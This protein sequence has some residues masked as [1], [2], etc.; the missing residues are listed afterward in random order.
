MTQAVWKSI[1]EQEAKIESDLI[2]ALDNIERT[3]H[4]STKGDNSP[5]AYVMRHRLGVELLAYWDPDHERFFLT[6]LGLQRRLKHRNQEPSKVLSFRRLPKPVTEK[7][8]GTR[9]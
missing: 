1:E 8:T 2:K 4:F 3:G 7:A 6:S 9:G 5:A